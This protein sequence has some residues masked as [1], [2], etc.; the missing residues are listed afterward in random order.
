MRILKTIKSVEL[1]PQIKELL[2]NGHK[3]RITVTGSS[4]MP[5]LRENIDS[6]ELSAASFESLRFGQIPLIRRAD[7]QYI[8]HRLIIKKK[9]CFYIMGDAQLW[10]EG[11]IYPEQLIAVVTKIWR[12]DRQISASNIIWNILSFIWWLRIP[13]H[14]ILRIPYRLLKKVYRVVRKK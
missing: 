6:V 2:D 5:F 10:I 4:M 14:R 11:P 1:F 3:V 8:L 13:A 9:D 7:G 12:G